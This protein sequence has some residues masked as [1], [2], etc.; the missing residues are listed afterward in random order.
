MHFWSHLQRVIFRTDLSKSKGHLLLE[1][2]QQDNKIFEI[3]PHSRT[4]WILRPHCSSDSLAIPLLL[5]KVNRITLNNPNSNKE[6]PWGSTSFQRTP[7]RMHK[8]Q[9][10]SFSPGQSHPNQWGNQVYF[11][12]L[13]WEDENIK[14]ITGNNQRH[15]N[16]FDSVSC[17]DVLYHQQC[18]SGYR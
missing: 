18:R 12:L 8:M 2:S 5:L 15:E 9:S 13:W 7:T 14:E 1:R 16:Q 6:L 11:I 10:I 4:T 3:D 17:E